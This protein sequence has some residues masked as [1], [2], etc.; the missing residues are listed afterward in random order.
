MLI[1]ALG[2][3]VAW[4]LDRG[5]P[6]WLR[7]CEALIKQLKLMHQTRVIVIEETGWGVVPATRIGCLFRDRLGEL[8]QALQ[9][10]ADASWLVIQGRAINLQTHSYPVP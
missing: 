7:Q 5:E 2:G 8:A 10:H 3:F 6:E 4:N 9:V 1:D